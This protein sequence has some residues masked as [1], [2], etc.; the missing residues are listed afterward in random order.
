MERLRISAV[1]GVVVGL[2]VA[3]LP[4][5]ASAGGGFLSGFSTIST[6]GTT[7]PG[8]GDVNPYGIVVVPK[9]AG[10][11]VAGDVLI[12]NFNNSNNFQGTGSTLV[13]LS[14][15][16][17]LT[18]FAQINASHLPGK[19][20]G[21]VG[22]T[23]AL[24]VLPDG[25]VAVGS[26]PTTDGMPDTIG[27]GCILIL[28]SRGTVVET[29]SGRSINGPWD[30]TEANTEDGATLFV[31]NV[32]NGT[33]GAGGGVVNRGTVVRIR[34]QIDG[35]HRPRVTSETTV[36]SGLGERTDRS[37]LVV[38]PTGLGLGRDGTLYVADSEYNRIAAIPDA[39]TRHDTA[40]S[41]LDVTANGLINDPLGLTIAPNGD[42]V[43][44]NGGD[45][46]LVETTPQGTQLAFKQ[47]DGS[48]T[49]PGAGALFGLAVAPHGGGVYFVDDATNML[50]LLH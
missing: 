41:G 43:S 6:V 21:G 5:A 45:G 49:P 35:H 40:F 38:G 19:C 14:P 33:V 23:T 11:L 3:G 29:I 15:T 10:R 48:G 26:L 25:F 36:A 30:M 13:E 50:E 37:A 27:A 47:V 2:A 7:V 20:P 24:D 17:N 39:L 31:T 4:L 46:N 16:G 42:I 9:S 18:L 44:A 1:V 22:L 28:D 12:S 8:N 34:L 32:L